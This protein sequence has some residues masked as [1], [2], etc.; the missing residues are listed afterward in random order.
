MIRSLLTTLILVCSFDATADRVVHKEKSLYRNIMVTESAGRRCLAFSVKRQK[1][2]Q[3][4]INLSNPDDLVFP[5]VRMTFAALLANPAPRKAMMIGL[6]GGTISNVLV[7]EFPELTIDV[8]EVDEAVVK[9]AR[10]YFG[11]IENDRTRIHVADGRVFTRRLVHRDEKYDLII[12]DAFTGE[13]IPEHLMTK[14]FLLDIKSLLTEDGVVVA[15]TFAR[16]DLYHH[17][18]VTYAEVFGE[19]INFKMPGTGN[20]VIVAAK[21]ELPDSQT[22]LMNARMLEEQFKPYSVALV[23]YA[24]YLDREPDWNPRKRALTDQFSPANLLRN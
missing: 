21:N 8:A 15:N 19:L 10:D 18:S 4:C 23:K 13:Y 22:L 11:L 7:T 12:L 9:V 24:G 20:R 1:R 3:T 17:E 6:G 2:N 14:E 5:Y 16:S